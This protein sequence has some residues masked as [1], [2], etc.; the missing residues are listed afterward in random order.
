MFIVKILLFGLIFIVIL[1][2]VVLRFIYK[3]F[4]S[5]RDVQEEI[6]N[7]SGR[8]FSRQD[9]IRYQ[10]EQREKNPFGDDYFRSADAPKEASREKQTTT[11]K[12]AAGSGVTIIDERDTAE[13]KKIFGNG[14]GEYVEYEEV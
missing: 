4:R 12:T 13:K 1:A 5:I 11:R 2:L 7:A 10:R 3:G 8:R 6:I 9:Y 14:D